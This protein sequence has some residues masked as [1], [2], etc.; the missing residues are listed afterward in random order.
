MQS[1]EKEVGFFH[2]D[3]AVLCVQ[4]QEKAGKK[5][6]AELWREIERLKESLPGNT[7][8]GGGVPCGSESSE[9]IGGV[10]GGNDGDSDDEN[11][12]E[13]FFLRR[14]SWAVKK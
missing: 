7:K 14:S 9:A 12:P 13:L 4:M 8:G 5:E 1:S 6:M 10:Q 2:P 3:N 11:D